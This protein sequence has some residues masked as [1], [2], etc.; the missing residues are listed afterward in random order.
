MGLID[1]FEPLSTFLL[2]ALSKNLRKHQNNF[3][4]NVKNKIFGHWVRPILCCLPEGSSNLL[5]I[6]FA[7]P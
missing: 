3:F 7:N 5:R 4:G 1:I 2:V 6:K